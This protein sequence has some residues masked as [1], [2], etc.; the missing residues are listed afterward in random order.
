MT[1]EIVVDN[2]LGREERKSEFVRMRAVGKSYNQIAEKLIQAPQRAAEP[3]RCFPLYYPCNHAREHPC[4]KLSTACL[5]SQFSNGDE[6][7]K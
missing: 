2:D 4:A 1:A 3:I 7:L 6:Y 5:C